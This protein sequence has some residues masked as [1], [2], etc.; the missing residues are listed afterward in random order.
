MLFHKR[1]NE[2]H[3]IQERENTFLSE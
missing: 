3:V 1:H 2:L